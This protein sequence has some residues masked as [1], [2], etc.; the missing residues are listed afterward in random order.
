MS[1]LFF[2]KGRKKK[3]KPSSVLSSNE[4]IKNKKVFQMIFSPPINKEILL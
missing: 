3:K 2:E 1:N 4:N